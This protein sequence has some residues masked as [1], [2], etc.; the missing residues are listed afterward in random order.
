MIPVAQFAEIVNGEFVREYP[1]NIE[2]KLPSMG[3][4]RSD[5]LKIKNEARE[6]RETQAA[7]PSMVA[8][9][10]QPI[11]AAMRNQ[12]PALVD[13]AKELFA[14]LQNLQND[15]A[16][17]Q[18]ALNAQ[19]L[20]GLELQLAEQYRLCR[21]LL[22]AS[23]R[24]TPKINRVKSTL[25]DCQRSCNRLGASLTQVR[26]QYPQTST[27]PTDLEMA[28]WQTKVDQAES[29]Y[30]NELERLQ[31]FVDKLK[32]LEQEAQEKQYA[33]SAAS[34]KCLKLRDRIAALKT[35]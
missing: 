1:N 5:E 33:L 7:K 31:G 4:S 12:D 32:E 29:A 23:E 28:A 2:P 21:Q 17:L 8:V 19:L 14:T 22:D 24:L 15:I 30:A 9:N 35:V 3:I 10:Q 16:D 6:F 27:W 34:Q 13:K 25:Q 18:A 26:G 11:L 20:P